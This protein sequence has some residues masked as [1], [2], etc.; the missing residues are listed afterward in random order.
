MNGAKALLAINVLLYMYRG[1]SGKQARATELFRLYATSGHML[2]STPVGQE[3]CAAG[4]RKRGMPLQEFRD[5]TMAPLD[6]PVVIVGLPQIRSDIQMRSDSEFPS[7][8]ALVLA[9]AE[10]GGSEILF[11]EDLSDGQRYGGVL[12]RNPFRAAD[13]RSSKN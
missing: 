11:T 6:C 1:D 2:L 3:F 12:V 13:S 4:L 5:A 7:G 10:S 8:T 9:A